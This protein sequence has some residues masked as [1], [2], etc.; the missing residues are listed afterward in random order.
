MAAVSNVFTVRRALLAGGAV[1]LPFDVYAGYLMV[2]RWGTPRFIGSS[3]HC[4]GSAYET[5]RRQ[6]ED[7][8]GV[9]SE[10]AIGDEGDAE[11]IANSLPSA[12]LGGVDLSGIDPVKL[13]TLHSIVL[14]KEHDYGLEYA[15]SEEG[16]WVFKFPRELV[17]ALAVQTQAQQ[18]D[19]AARWLTTDEFSIDG[20]GLENVEATLRTI[21]EQAKRASASSRALFLWVSL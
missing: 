5:A 1:V 14:G 12:D 3:A 18:M 10:L 19:V 11:K 15:S 6:S 17:D 21:C 9:L 13:G 2:S 20:W 16:P 4:S 8:V 7:D